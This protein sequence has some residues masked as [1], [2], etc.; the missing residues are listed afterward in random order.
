MKPIFKSRAF[1]EITQ[2]NLSW[3]VDSMEWD[4]HGGPRAAQLT[5][6]G[7]DNATWQLAG[8]LRAPVTIYDDKGQ[9]CWWGFVSEVHMAKPDAYVGVGYSLDNMANN[10]ACT[11]SFIEPGGTVVGQRKTTAFASYAYGTATYG[12][13][14]Y[15]VSVDGMTNEAGT[16]VRDTYLAQ[17]QIPPGI[18]EVG[19]AGISVVCRGWWETMSWR[20]ASNSGTGGTVITSHLSS[21]VTSYGQFLNGAIL[22][23]T[24][25]G[26]ISPYFSGD[27]PAYEEAERL[28]A[29]GGANQRRT[30]VRV[31]ADRRAIF[32]EEPAPPTGGTAAYYLDRRG[33]FYNAS[34][35]L[36]TPHM[37]YA[38]VGG[39]VR[40]RDVSAISP[41]I[42]LLQDP[43][44]QFLE[45]LT[46]NAGVLT[47]EFRGEVNVRDI[48]KAKS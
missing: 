34:G 38:A 13:K 31:D 25:A 43:S 4:C 29:M 20:I 45:G 32:Y 44:V 36:I 9:G 1:A 30:L 3:R 33:N 42:T 19:A 7:G 27:Y 17:H 10:V 18:A 35:G 37:A 15:I 39:Y 48:V 16:L 14:D 28:M 40:L 47:P 24:N 26:T 46:W 41:D 21:L 5:P 6:T 8:M 11:Y 12:Q 22:E 23:T 2:P